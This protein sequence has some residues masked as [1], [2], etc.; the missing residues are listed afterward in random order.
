MDSNNT[1]YSRPKTAAV[2]VRE[3]LWNMFLI[4]YSVYLSHEKRQSST[5]KYMSCST[6][7]CSVRRLKSL[8]FVPQDRILL[9]RS[10]T[11]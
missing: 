2:W 5:L 3:R 6:F 9:D 7:L 4:I 11:D 1:C 10:V 8:R